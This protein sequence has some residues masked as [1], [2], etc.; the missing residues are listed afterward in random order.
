MR[1]YLVRLGWGHGDAE[2]V[3]TAQAIEWFDLDAIGR[4]ASRFDFKKLDSVN[5]HYL[6]NSS[7]ARVLEA[8]APLIE[9][10]AGVAIDDAA[11]ARLLA[12]MAGLKARA[13]TLL[14]LANASVFYVKARPL[15]LDDAARKLLAGDGMTHLRTARDILTAAAEWAAPALE[16]SFRAASEAAGIKLGT[17]AQPVRAAL[18]GQGTSPPVF[19]MMAILGRAETLGR[20][21]DALAT[22]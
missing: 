2:I 8:A 14:E 3:D 1:N 4:S 21:D 16:A 20:V 10:A 17:L 9:K 7:D 13:K 19:E 22:G 5:G 6:R 15:P 18:S 11:R 12:G